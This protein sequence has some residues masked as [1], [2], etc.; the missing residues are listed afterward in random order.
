[1]SV[2]QSIANATA[3]LEELIP[4]LVAGQW[5]SAREI[6]ALC[7]YFRMRGVC[8]MLSEGTVDGLHLN[9]M[10]DAGAY[11]HWLVEAEEAEKV[12][13]LAQPAFAA[14]AAG[15]WQ[16]AEQIATHSRISH[17]PRFEHEDDFLYVFF[18]MQRY[19]RGASD[20]EQRRSLTEYERVL[21]GQRDVKL[22]LCR[23]LCDHAQDDFEDAL[24][25]LLQHRQ[26]TLDALA[27]EGKLSDEHLEW[28]RPFATEGLALLRIGEREGFTLSGYYPTIPEMTRSVAVRSWSP[29]AWRALDYAG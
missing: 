3:A 12:T 17:N 2:L 1:M 15:Y 14:V 26:R 4:G 28:A 5:R 23:A 6:H 22:D 18:I 10:Q 13:S 8:R 24:V 16:A 25:E 7:A 20:A 19:L 27:A 9:Q 21:D 11:L 29:S